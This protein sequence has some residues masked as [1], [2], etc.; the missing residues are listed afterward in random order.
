MNAKHKLTASL[1]GS[2]IGFAALFTTLAPVTLALTTGGSS[3][4]V[5]ADGPTDCPADT[6]WNGT[7]CANDTHW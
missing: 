6:H 4:S 3:V 1:L 2:L 7:E 5:V